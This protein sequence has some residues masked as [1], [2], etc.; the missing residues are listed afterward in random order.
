MKA[1]AGER[2]CWT[3]LW[4]QTRPLEFNPDPTCSGAPYKWVSAALFCSLLV[5]V[6]FPVYHSQ[7]YF[8]LIY[9]TAL[10]IPLLKKHELGAWDR[11]KKH[12]IV[13]INA[14][15]ISFF[16]AFFFAPTF[17]LQLRTLGMHFDESEVFMTLGHR[18]FRGNKALAVIQL[19]IKI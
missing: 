11:Q 19:A 18:T 8:S 13:K 9:G 15:C 2:W 16:G 3:R 10:L 17:L 12:E 4:L 14:R 7:L 5:E 6:A 1:Q